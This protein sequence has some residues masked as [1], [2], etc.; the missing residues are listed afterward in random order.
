MRGLRLWLTQKWNV[1]KATSQAKRMSITAMRTKRCDN[2]EKF[3]K[4]KI[5]KNKKEKQI[6]NLKLRLHSMRRP[7]LTDQNQVRHMTA[8][9]GIDAR[10]GA[11]QQ[12]PRLQPGIGQ[13]TANASHNV[14]QAHSAMTL[15]QFQR[16]TD[17][18]LQNKQASA[19][20]CTSGEGSWHSHL[21]THIDGEMPLV[22]V[23]QHVGEV[24]P[25]LV[26]RLWSVDEAAL[27]ALVGNQIQR[28]LQRGNWHERDLIER[29]K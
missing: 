10:R 6:G 2:C 25:V 20:K 29:H 16:D 28:D 27:H 3:W 23:Q 8:Q 26:P 24:A 11:H 4:C 5:E 19:G 9:H 12:Q 17:K 7:Q 18:A 21:K 13:C 22:R 15:L 1:V 14:D